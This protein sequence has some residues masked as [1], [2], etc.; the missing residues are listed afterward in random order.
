MEG[1]DSKALKQKYLKDRI[2]SAGYD[3]VKF[4]NFMIMRRNN[5]TDV[6]VWEMDELMEVVEDFIRQQ[7]K[8]AGVYSE[9]VSDISDKYKDLEEDLDEPYQPADY[10]DEDKHGAHSPLTPPKDIHFPS[11]NEDVPRY[12]T[13][14]DYGPRDDTGS[15][16]PGNQPNKRHR[17]QTMSF[18]SRREQIMSGMPVNDTIVEDES[19]GNEEDQTGEG[20]QG[21][22][23]NLRDEIEDS[24]PYNYETAKPKQEYK[25]DN[26]SQEEE[27]KDVTSPRMARMQTQAEPYTVPGLKLPLTEL[28]RTKDLRI[29]VIGSEIVD[30]GFFSAKYLSFKLKVLPWDTVIERR[31]KDFNVLHDYFV[32]AF[33]HILIPPINGKSTTKKY[34]EWYTHKRKFII[35][36]FMNK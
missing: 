18:F 29:E 26:R 3:K 4:A 28:N 30:E 7:E 14:V 11:K 22:N 12:A 1:E 21:G 2:L 25:G 6:D 33:P 27:R 17:D 9:P 24:K 20:G 13:F 23:I 34:D 19:P 32:K 31:D 5:G 15:L 36:R 16:E 8:E 35:K 10:E